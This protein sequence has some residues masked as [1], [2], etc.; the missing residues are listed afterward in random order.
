MKLSSKPIEGFFFFLKKAF[1]EIVTK[2]KYMVGFKIVCMSFKYEHMVDTASTPTNKK[3][4]R[5]IFFTQKKKK[6]K[7]QES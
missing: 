2:H 6:L 7:R 3:T 4:T 5:L 1:I